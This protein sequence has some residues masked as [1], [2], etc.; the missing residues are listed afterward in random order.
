MSSN[1]ESLSIADWLAMRTPAAPVALQDVLRELVGNTQCTPRE[2]PSTLVRIA[3]RLFDK[4]GDSRESAALLLAADALITYAMEAAA[5]AGVE[6]A[7]DVA[8]KTIGSVG[9]R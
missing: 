2:L 9:N 7:A 4:L 6:D 8:M 1:S 5:D 3:A